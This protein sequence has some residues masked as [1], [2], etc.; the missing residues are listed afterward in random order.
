MRKPREIFDSIYSESTLY[1]IFEEKVKIKKSTGRDGVRVQTFEKNIADEIATIL[2]KVKAKTYK[3]TRYKEKVISKG[4]GRFP[5]VLSIPT[6]RDRLALRGL[7]E[8]LVA[9]FSDSLTK[10]PHAYIKNI[11]E[12]AKEVSSEW[13][14]VRV[15]VKDY[16]GTIDKSIL[17]RNVKRKTRI[18]EAI[19]LI[20]GA[21]NTPTLKAGVAEGGIPQGLSISNILAAIYLESVD[22][23]IKSDYQYWR[24]VDDI[25]ILCPRE[26]ALSAFEKLRKSLQRKNLFCYELDDNSGKSGV[27]GVVDG[28]DYLGFHIN[29]KGVSIRRSSYRKMFGSILSILTEHSYR[30][31]N[32]KLIWKLNLKITGC[33]FEGVH[34]GWMFFFIQ[35]DDMRQLSRLDYFIKKQ[36]KSRGFSNLHPSVKRFVKSYNEIR[37]NLNATRY[38][39]N[40]D[41]FTTENMRGELAAMTGRPLAFFQTLDNKKVQDDFFRLI[42]KEVANLE[43]DLFESF[44]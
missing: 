15:D 16:Y 14:F 21:I 30:K 8:F 41:N 7:C 5:R 36:L 44:S 18:Q 43:R 32:E 23:A 6:V 1:S 20:E 24:Y 9:V 10:K 4:P 25:L 12:L 13:V 11:K 39:P 27:F 40:F 38:I 2:R 3:F 19:C 31:S 42:R 22:A 37:F 35:S 29:N 33:I 17:V 34:Y 26:D 28:V